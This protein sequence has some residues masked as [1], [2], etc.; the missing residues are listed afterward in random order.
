MKSTL[1]EKYLQCIDTP[2]VLQNYI[3]SGTRLI[4]ISECAIQKKY[5][6]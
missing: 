3:D 6:I 4:N 1:Q 5:V 2:V